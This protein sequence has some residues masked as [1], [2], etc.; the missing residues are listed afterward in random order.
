M[1]HILWESKK[2]TEEEL[3]IQTM[4]LFSTIEKKIKPFELLS[5]ND[6]WERVEQL[7]F[8]LSRLEEN[9]I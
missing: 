8:Q 1:H 5:L 6:K 3:R 9:Y 2:I 4:R 7:A